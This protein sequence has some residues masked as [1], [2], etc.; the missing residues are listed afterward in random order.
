MDQRNNSFEIKP[1]ICEDL[2]IN[3][4]PFVKPLSMFIVSQLMI[5]Y[6]IFIANRT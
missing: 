5:F 1:F 4:A 2:F 6:V 3:L